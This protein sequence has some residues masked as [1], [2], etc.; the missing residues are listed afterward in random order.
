MRNTTTKDARINGPIRGYIDPESKVVTLRKSD[1][2]VV[3]LKWESMKESYYLT[4]YGAGKVMPLHE[5]AI[6]L[7]VDHTRTIV[8]VLVVPD[9]AQTVPV[10]IGQPFTEQQHITMVKRKDTLTIFQEVEER[11]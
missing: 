6:D 2:E 4:G 5:S 10:L 3:G 1:T 8:V 9:E 7:E 11:R